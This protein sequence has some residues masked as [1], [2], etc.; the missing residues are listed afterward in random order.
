MKQLGKTFRV[1]KCMIVEIIADHLGRW[2]K[3]H[4]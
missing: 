3:V 4:L 2:V 1:G